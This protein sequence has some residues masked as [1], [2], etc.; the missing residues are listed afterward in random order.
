VYSAP[1]TAPAIAP[2]MVPQHTHAVTSPA[3]ADARAASAARRTAR[4]GSVDSDT[5]DVL[6][7]EDAMDAAV[8][9]AVDVVVV[10]GGVARISS[11]PRA[12]CVPERRFRR[13]RSLARRYVGTGA[14]ARERDAR[15]R[16][17][18][19]SR[20]RRSRARRSR[21]E[22]TSRGRFTYF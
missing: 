10:G 12:Q 2:P 13:A 18:R 5:M 21:R 6:E 9:R 8:A 19:W 22:L 17:A 3:L 11:S 7:T 15:R 16:G 20:A 14:R 1:L 4:V